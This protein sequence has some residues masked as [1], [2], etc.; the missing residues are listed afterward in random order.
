MYILIVLFYNQSLRLF[1]WKSWEWEKI[2][3][4]ASSFVV[5]N[6]NLFFSLSFCI[7]ISLCKFNIYD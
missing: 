4:F 2:A 7:M 6:S 5:F 1:V 3:G